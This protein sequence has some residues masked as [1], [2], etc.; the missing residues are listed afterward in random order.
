MRKLLDV[1]GRCETGSGTEDVVSAGMGIGSSERVLLV[2]FS[3]RT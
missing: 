2:R 1:R 3:I